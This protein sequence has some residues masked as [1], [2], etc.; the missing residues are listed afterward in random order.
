[1]ADTTHSAGILARPPRAARITIDEP[2]STR[3]EVK[4]T[5]EEVTAHSVAL[6][7]AQQALAVPEP[8]VVGNATIPSDAEA[9]STSAAPEDPWTT[10]FE[11]CRTCQQK[12]SQWSRSS[13]FFASCKALGTRTVR[14]LPD[15]E[16]FDVAQRETTG[17]PLRHR[18]ASQMSPFA[19]LTAKYICLMLR[20]SHGPSP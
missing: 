1:M 2:A 8:Y 4:V 11:S 12:L 13:A 17:F 18:I 5:S 15:V 14:H 7:V 6:P 19:T 3:A 16:L 9:V 10:I 20:H